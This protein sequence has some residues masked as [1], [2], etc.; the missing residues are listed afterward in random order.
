MHGLESKPIVLH[1]GSGGHMGLALNY[2]LGPFRV[3]CCNSETM[4]M[5]HNLPFGSICKV[6]FELNEH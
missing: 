1:V 5:G 2:K 6:P 4:Q 3:L